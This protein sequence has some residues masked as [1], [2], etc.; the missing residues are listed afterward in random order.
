MSSPCAFAT[1]AHYFCAI[2]APRSKALGRAAELSAMRPVSESFFATLDK[3]L[4]AAEP[5]RPGSA[6][7]E[8]VADHIDN[9]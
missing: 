1:R 2:C 4:L 3:E 7:R 5:L 8:M 9:S 6:T